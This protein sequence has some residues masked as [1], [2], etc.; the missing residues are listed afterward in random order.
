MGMIRM[1]KKYLIYLCEKNKKIL[2]S[3]YLITIVTSFIYMLLGTKLYKDGNSNIVAILVITIGTMLTIAGFVLFIA[4]SINL[5]YSDLFS[6]VGKFDYSLPISTIKKQVSKQILSIVSTILLIIIMMLSIL[7]F[8]FTLGIMNFEDIK[9][10]FIEILKVFKY[11][12]FYKVTVYYFI[13]VLAITNLTYTISIF[14][15]PVINTKLLNVVTSLFV[16]SFIL[17]IPSLFFINDEFLAYDV[18]DLLVLQNSYF[19]LVLGF[20]VIVTILSYLLLN[21]VENKYLE[22]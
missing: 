4:F 21:Y 14:I 11:L 15:K 8:G 17:K 20:T 19:F 13:K 22:I 16:V 10:I 1:I 2:L 9:N 5:F 6:P 3:G 12:H 18:L 7:V